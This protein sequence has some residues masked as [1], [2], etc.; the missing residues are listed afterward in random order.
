[1]DEAIY[2]SDRVVVLSP[3]PASVIADVTVPLARPRTHEV[4]QAKEFNDTRA[5]ILSAFKSGGTK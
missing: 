2:L 3:L 1:L 4:L 5:T